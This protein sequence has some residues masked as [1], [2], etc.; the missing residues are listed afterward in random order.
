MKEK[1]LRI[2][3]HRPS[4][5]YQKTVSMAPL[6][7][8]RYMQVEAVLKRAKEGKKGY[9]A[10]LDRYPTATDHQEW[11]V[12]HV[13]TS[14]DYTSLERKFLEIQVALGDVSGEH[15]LNISERKRS[16]LDVPT[17]AAG[18]SV[19]QALRNEEFFVTEKVAELHIVS[20]WC[21]ETSRPV[22]F[23]SEAEVV[24]FVSSDNRILDSKEA[25]EIA[26]EAGQIKWFQREALDRILT[27][28]MLE[29]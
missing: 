26:L 6:N 17:R 8:V 15:C 19:W 7:N 10:L 3:L 29:L 1:H 5:L 14:S 22:R 28:E 4:G 25:F 21:M 9:G 16:T 27:L 2:V 13:A 18:G 23:T 12:I 20:G 11:E 24:G